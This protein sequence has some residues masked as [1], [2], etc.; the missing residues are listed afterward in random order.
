MKRRYLL[1]FILSVLLLGCKRDARLPEPTGPAPTA[2]PTATPAVPNQTLTLLD[3]RKP[4]GDGNNVWYIPN[5]VVESL[6]VSNIYAFG[7]DLLLEANLTKYNEDGEFAGLFIEL[8]RVS[9]A[10]GSLLAQTTLPIGGS[11]TVQ[12]FGEWVC[13]SDSSAGTITILDGAL[14]QTAHYQVE[15]NDSATWY[16]SADMETLYSFDRSNGVDSIQLS[17]G[18]KTQMLPDARQ[19]SICNVSPRYVIFSY[20]DAKSLLDSN[21]CLNL[22]TGILEPTPLEGALES[23]S[24]RN[25]D[26]WVVA[27]LN[28]LESYTIGTLDSQ[29]LLFLKDHTISVLSQQEHLLAVDFR[30]RNLTLYDFDGTFISHCEVPEDEMSYTRADL[31]W[32]N[33][34]NGYFFLNFQNGEARLFFWDIKA[35]SS[36]ENLRFNNKEE[37]SS[38]HGRIVDAALYDRARELSERFS[39][40]IRIADRCQL[41]YG[42]ITATA[43]TNP[44]SIKTALDKLEE[45][46]SVYPEGFLKQL[47]YGGIR[48]L[49]IDLVSNIRNLDG[50]DP[51]AA[52]AQDGLIVMDTHSVATWNFYHEVAHIIDNRLAFDA[53]QRKDA[54][55]S[56]EAWLALQPVG[57]EYAYS[58][59]YAY[60]YD[61][62]VGNADPEYFVIPY[63]MTFPTED[64]A[65]LMEAAMSG[66]P[67]FADNERLREKLAFYSQCI[68]DSFDTTGWPDVALWERPLAEE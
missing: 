23:N 6:S 66:T 20:V 64:R 3:F 43:E 32:S 18:T 50:S 25:G 26:V 36:G 37:S 45:A 65:T 11:V 30:V 51:S 48:T 24:S 39:V 55:F 31:I 27:K 59:N 4:V 2:T 63:S 49:Q 58:Y 16:V 29:K 14:E 7:E 46:M 13:L 5:D 38:L 42:N 57:F 56:E 40:D 33:R 28:D 61:A 1:V 19:I 12:I 9:L 60:T 21:G 17:S 47:R 41:N 44:D 68:R 52:Y 10:D 22:E 35:E 62:P 54:L 8:K 34:W 67:I 15:S 53:S